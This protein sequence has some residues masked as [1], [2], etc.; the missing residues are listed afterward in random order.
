MVMFTPLEETVKGTLLL[1][2]FSAV[3]QLVNLENC[4]QLGTGSKEKFCATPQKIMAL[5]SER[6]VEVAAGGNHSIAIT[7]SGDVYHWG[8]L[9]H[10]VEA[11]KRDFD[12]A[13][14]MPGMREMADRKRRMLDRSIAEYYANGQ[15]LQNSDDLDTYNTSNLNFG[16]FKSYI[17]RTPKLLEGLGNVRIVKAAA[18][19]GFSL[20]LSSTGQ[21]YSYG[22][23]DKLARNFLPTFTSISINLFYSN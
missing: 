23:N 12:A 11:E 18:G 5:A 2:F 13:I 1:D 7:S 9:H 16:N 14:A 17:Q 10:V 20:L 6:I 19:Y 21:V 15:D 8:R 4:S 22:F 3:D